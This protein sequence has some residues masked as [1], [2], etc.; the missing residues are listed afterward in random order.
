MK[1]LLKVIFLKLWEFLRWEKTLLLSPTP[2][3]ITDFSSVS[4]S[5]VP[6]YIGFHTK[7]IKIEYLW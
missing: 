5:E 4:T 1:P 6:S 7:M 2:M 3:Y